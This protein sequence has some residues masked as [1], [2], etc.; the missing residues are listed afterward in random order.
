MKRERTA[1]VSV[2][3]GIK[4]KLVGIVMLL[5][6]GSI[7]TLTWTQISS[8]QRLLEAELNKR[9]NLMK[10][11]LASKGVNVITHLSAQV[12]K[13]I[14]SYNFSA[15][16][17]DLNQSVGKNGELKGAILTN[18]NN[19]VFVHTLNPELLRTKLDGPADREAVAA[20]E[21]TIREFRKDGESLMEIVSPV[22]IST[23]PWG[24]LRLFF[25]LKNL[26]AE[27][28]S[29]YAQIEK[30]EWKMYRRTMLTSAV[31]LAVS[32]VIVLFLSARF[33]SPLIRL[34]KS[35]REISKGNF[36]QKI[37]IGRKDEV[38]VLAD[39]MNTMISNLGEMIRKNV[40]T[41]DDL[42]SGIIH[43]TTSLEE[44]T[45]LLDEMSS[46]TR[47]NAIN[48]NQADT[49]M[50][51]T[52]QVVIKA[53]ETMSRLTASINEISGA[54]EETFK[55]IKTIDEIAFQTNLL[56]LNA[57]V[58]AARAGETGAGFAVVAE[59]V[60]NLA[61]RSAEAAKNTAS[62]IED[63][64]SKIKDGTDL[65]NHANEGFNEVAANAAKVAELVSEISAASAEQKKRIEKT[66]QAMS[67][68]NK[69]IRENSCSAEGLTASMEVFKM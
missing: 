13:N 7:A 23:S 51:E 4:W 39:A 12:E 57:A 65:V 15:L 66:S 18:A 34:T 63:T 67:K 36:T 68:M 32:F 59:E 45:M 69:V 24:V 21:I 35:A 62:M 61:M 14:V 49:F 26:D 10:E 60:R 52:N 41:A 44:T 50:K 43:Q 27:I 54:S 48:A 42:S 22:Q 2:T 29:S 37:E 64:V 8:R 20:T 58:E 53:N 56:A 40:C 17:E 16:V 30:E 1:G 3:L 55:I 25:S 33:L 47:Q 28:E 31:F 9:V 6:I 19:L 46:M 38:G 5:M 11:N